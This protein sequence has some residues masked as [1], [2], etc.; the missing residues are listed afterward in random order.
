[1]SLSRSMNVAPPPPRVDMRHSGV[2]DSHEHGE[3]RQHNRSYH[4]HEQLHQHQQPQHQ[5]FHSRTQLP[6][7]H[8]ESQLL[9]LKKDFQELQQQYQQKTQ[10]ASSLQ[11]QLQQQQHRESFQT[12]NQMP[13]NHLEGQV[14][15]QVKKD[16]LELQQQ[17]KQK[18]QEASNLQMQLQQ[19]QHRQTL[20]SQ[21]HLPDSHFE[22][23]LLQLKKDYQELQQHHQQKTQEA[24]SLQMQVQLQQ[25]Q[26]RQSLQ[27]QNQIPDSHLELQQLRKDYQELQQQYQQKAQEASSLQMQLQQLQHRQTLDS[28][29]QLPDSQKDGQLPEEDKSEYQHLQQQFQQKTQEASS[30]QLKLQQA[31]DTIEI[32]K[33]MVSEAHFTA[34]TQKETIQNQQN[35][36]S[37]LEH[38]CEVTKKSH[39]LLPPTA[40]SPSTD[41]VETQVVGISR[42]RKL[43]AE[44][45][46]LQGAL[47]QAQ[48]QAREDHEQDSVLLESMQQKFES[49]VTNFE[50][51][52]TAQDESF[53]EQ[54]ATVT[55]LESEAASLKE[56]IAKH[57]NTI[58]DLHE[59]VK[60]MVDFN[61]QLETTHG[62]EI[63]AL[64]SE[65]AVC[66]EELRAANAT[67]ETQK[68]TLHHIQM[69]LDKQENIS[70]HSGD[71]LSSAKEE[72]NILKK[73]N[74]K[75]HDILFK[76][77]SAY[78]SQIR[79]LRTALS[80]VKDNVIVLERSV[81]SEVEVMNH[82]T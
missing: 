82:K 62:E 65:A 46:R 27:L 2:F 15:Q 11:M 72:L 53:V 43:E 54:E 51:S 73:K 70:Q 4:D 78:G 24:S 45:V 18:A 29:C 16:Y 37:E 13:D 48:I 17:Y 67:V 68:E 49:L 40:T 66:K 36:I 56:T 6:D 10:E 59:E 1:M 23:Q 44:I 7:S 19:Q 21:S 74:K 25:Q 20:D 61:R 81:E 33:E 55:G 76:I 39:H 79:E 63:S 64:E 28:Q 57:E 75:L 38:E 5:S 50:L 12:Q 71:N 35:V 26:H 30:L 58:T 60:T 80:R 34:D 41:D 52:R 32:M 31:S 69:D 42:V 22:S 9:Q 8:F 77:E 47:T 14:L 3:H